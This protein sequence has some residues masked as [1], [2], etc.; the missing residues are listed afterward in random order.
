[1][2]EPPPKRVKMDEFAEA[3]QAAALFR[4]AG[5]DLVTEE[6]LE[7]WAVNANLPS[8]ADAE[9][10]AATITSAYL[11]RAE[12]LEK[13]KQT[14]LKDEFSDEM[15]ALKEKAVAKLLAQKQEADAVA[16]AVAV[17]DRF[18]ESRRAKALLEEAKRTLQAAQQQEVKRTLQ[19]Q[20]AAARQQPIVITDAIKEEWA[21][22]KTSYLVVVYSGIVKE[23][24]VTGLFRAGTQFTVVGGPDMP[25]YL[26]A[27]V[28]GGRVIVIS[29][30]AFDGIRT[31]SN[32]EWALAPRVL[33]V[34]ISE[35]IGKSAK[36]GDLMVST[37]VARGAQ[38]I[39]AP[40]PF[41]EFIGHM[42][43][44][45]KNWTAKSSTK[46]RGENTDIEFLKRAIHAMY[47]LSELDKAW[48]EMFW[49]A[50]IGGAFLA[51]QE[52]RDQ[53]FRI[54]HDLQDQVGSMIARLCVNSYLY[55]FQNIVLMPDNGRRKL[56]EKETAMM[57]AKIEKSPLYPFEDSPEPETVM[58]VGRVTS[59]DYCVKDTAELF[60]QLGDNI[61]GIG[62]T[63]DYRNERSFASL[64]K[65]PSTFMI[66]DVVG[67]PMHASTPI[68]GRIDPKA[69]GFS[70]ATTFALKTW[71]KLKCDAHV[72]LL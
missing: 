55:I 19:P 36:P 63:G 8:K 37:S 54:L 66:V 52:L 21:R 44:S 16:A 72:P 18:V 14:D 71:E 11:R 22:W 4:P 46:K 24:H 2:F 60:Q 58:H 25:T 53:F 50:K 20:S 23:S 48:L 42:A 17:L 49:P 33:F 10:H 27:N 67:S 65:Q 29:H 31:P 7:H 26:A 34:Y 9:Q 43:S 13:E 6:D 40:E 12:D 59:V 1:M 32:A 41:A 3:L 69:E 64:L 38:L 70:R 68:V 45:A 30:S 39:S 61:D 35:C 57:E 28:G 47:R 15:I 5:Q 56:S 62:Y 51:T